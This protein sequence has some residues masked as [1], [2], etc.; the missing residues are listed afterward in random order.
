MKKFSTAALLFLWAL[1]VTS[2]ANLRCEFL[3]NAPDAYRVTAGDTLWDIAARFLDDPWCWSAVWDHN[4]SVIADPHRIYPGQ[5]IHFDRAQHRLRLVE[6]GGVTAV[7]RS[8]SMRVEA[9]TSRTV[10][11]LPTALTARLRKTVLLQ[12]E[13]LDEVPRITSLR[14]G[15]RMA[16][17]GDTIVASG[18]LGSHTLFQVIR[19]AQAVT[20]PED[21]RTLGL[22]GLFIGSVRRQSTNE[23]E[24]HEFSVIT[25][26]SEILIGDRLVP[27]LATE[28]PAWWPHAAAGV[29]GHI[30]AVLRG[31]RWASTNDIVAINRGTQHGLDTGSVM[32]VVRKPAIHA[33]ARHPVPPKPRSEEV[34]TLLVF[35]VAER[36][37]LALVTRARDALTVGDRVE[38]I[39]GKTE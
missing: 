3:N 28:S 1:P 11:T 26:D 7:R 6:D 10:P 16:S 31:A 37:A 23:G 18:V 39:S 12:A 35:D 24:P 14:E 9:L 4:R 21:G 25:S 38:S 32:A 2:H 27:S 20:D 29:A 19:P 17:A 5:T 33:D 13:T 34:A 30:A 22:A 36:A 15:R 8:P